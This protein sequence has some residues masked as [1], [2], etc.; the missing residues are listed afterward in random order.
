MGKIYFQSSFV[1]FGR[2]ITS[3][4]SLKCWT[5]FV[6][7]TVLTK[8]FDDIDLIS[9]KCFAAF[10]IKLFIFGDEK[11][12]PATRPWNSGEQS[13]I[14][15]FYFSATSN[16]LIK[17]SLPSSWY[18]CHFS[19]AYGMPKFIG[20]MIN[21]NPLSEPTVSLTI[22]QTDCKLIWTPNSSGGDLIPTKEHIP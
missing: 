8:A 11:G 12:N 2:R 17:V 13:M 1:T 9:C 14:L 16:T 21:L 7:N 5:L 19:S 6:P 3:I 22:L 15:R 10:V 20:S 18:F 4:F